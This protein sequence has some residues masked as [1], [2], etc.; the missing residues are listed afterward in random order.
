MEKKDKEKKIKIEIEIEKNI[1]LDNYYTKAFIN[2]L[3]S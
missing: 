1:Y 2:K 3:F